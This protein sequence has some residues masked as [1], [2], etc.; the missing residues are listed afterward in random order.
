MT[1]KLQKETNQAKLSSLNESQENHPSDCGITLSKGGEASFRPSERYTKTKRH[2]YEKRNTLIPKKAHK[3]RRNQTGKLKNRKKNK[4]PSNYSL[5][6]LLS[7]FQPVAHVPSSFTFSQHIPL[8]TSH[9]PSMLRERL[10][11][12]DNSTRELL[13]HC[14]HSERGELR[15]FELHVS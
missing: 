7:N 8:L 5:S 11:C 10:V 15:D 6:D 1:G 3:L 13:W 14:E 2:T 12:C 4:K 9:S